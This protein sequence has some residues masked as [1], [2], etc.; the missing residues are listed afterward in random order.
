MKFD[1]GVMA[2]EATSNSH[3]LFPTLCNTNVMDAQS[4][5]VGTWRHCS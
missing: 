4:R 2:L 1:M 3:F 5:E